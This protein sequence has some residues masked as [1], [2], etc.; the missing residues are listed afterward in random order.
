MPDCFPKWLWPWT[1]PPLASEN[2]HRFIFSPTLDVIRHSIFTHLMHVKWYFIVVY[3]RLVSSHFNP[4]SSHCWI[5]ISVMIFWSCHVCSSSKCFKGFSFPFLFFSSEELG[6]SLSFLYSRLF[7]QRLPQS[8]ESS[9]SLL[10]PYIPGKWKYLLFS[11]RKFPP[12]SFCPQYPSASNALSIPSACW[13]PIISDDIAEMLLLPRSLPTSFSLLNPC[14][15]GLSVS[16]PFTMPSRILV[17]SECVCC[18]R[19]DLKS[20][21]MYF[22]LCIPRTSNIK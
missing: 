20:E 2:L 19:S 16:Y 1:L 3:L 7:H 22:C 14:H 21:T 8:A 15:T 17:R 6:T 13:N 5:N 11:N 12:P 9:T 18:P 10:V 4:S